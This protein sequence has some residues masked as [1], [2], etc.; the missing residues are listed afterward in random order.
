M[1]VFYNDYDV[2]KFGGFAWCDNKND[3]YTF[4]LDWIDFTFRCEFNWKISFMWVF[5]WIICC[6]LSSSL[7]IAFYLSR[8]WKSISTHTHILYIYMHRMYIMRICVRFVYDL[9]YSRFHWTW[10]WTH[11]LHRYFN[12]KLARCCLS[13]RTETMCITQ[14]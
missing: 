4:L 7:L 8:D 14:E 9:S 6:L 13:E 3:S 11:F 5:N 2:Y 10:A 12:Q 1:A